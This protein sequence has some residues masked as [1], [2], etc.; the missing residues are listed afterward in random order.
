MDCAKVGRLIYRLRHEKG[1][2][3]RQ[4]AD[5]LGVSDKAISKWERGLGCPDVTLLRA[6]SAVLGADIGSILAGD[7]DPNLQDGGNMKRLKFH[8]CA[9]CG[10]IIT[11]TGDADIACC[12]RKVPALV[13]RPADGEHQ[14]TV[15]EVEDDW[16]ITFPHEMHKEHFLRF[17]A[18][19]SYDRVLLVRLYPEQGSEVRMPKL[20]SSKFFTCCSEHG[21]MVHG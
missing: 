1:M 7:L 19:V 13:P 11:A 4:L 15:E 20:R 14:L 16:Y 8:V 12:G 3:Q 21:L 17:I 18:C 10:N 5:S 2:T 9:T 6:L